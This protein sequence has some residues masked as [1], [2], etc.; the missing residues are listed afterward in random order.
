MDYKSKILEYVYRPD[1]M[2]SVDNIICIKRI[3][4]PNSIIKFDVY[5]L[6]SHEI[7]NR[8][9][10]SADGALFKGIK[11]KIYVYKNMD[12]DIITKQG[13]RYNAIYHSTISY[14]AGTKILYLVWFGNDNIR[15][16]ALDRDVIIDHTKAN[17]RII[18]EL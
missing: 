8:E 15:P 2:K 14:Y 16:L 7:I 17:L 18:E 5:Y 11:D 1:I 12:I 4:E 13:I 10:I 3:Y 9:T 6:D